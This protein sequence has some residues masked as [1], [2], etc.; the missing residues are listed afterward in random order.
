MIKL[1]I[2][3]CMRWMR[4]VWAEH[5]YVF[6]IHH[7]TDNV[8][9]HMTVNRVHP[10]SYNAV[11]P[12]RDYFKLDYAMRELELRYGWTHDNGPYSVI[13]KRDRLKLP[14]QRLNPNFR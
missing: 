5:Q 11:Y 8:H 12:D 6:A 1:S 13:D 2:V 3:L 7:D 10:D 14:G 4:S 9:L